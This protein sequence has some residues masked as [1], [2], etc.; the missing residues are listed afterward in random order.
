MADGCY[1]VLL[2]FLLLA[3]NIFYTSFEKTIYKLYLQIVPQSVFTNMFAFRD[4][5]NGS[6]GNSKNFL[7]LSYLSKNTLIYSSLPISRYRAT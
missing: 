1:A 2:L 6:C 7:V 4:L 3:L 5:S